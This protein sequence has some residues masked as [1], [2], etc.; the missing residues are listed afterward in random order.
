SPQTQT[1]RCA[2]EHQP[3]C[4]LYS[5][6][7]AALSVIGCHPR[8]ANRTSVEIWKQFSGHKALT[9]VQRQVDL[10]PRPAGSEAIEKTRQYI[11]NQLQACGWR[12]LRQQFVDNTPRGAIQFVNLIAHF[13][14]ATPSFL[15]C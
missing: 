9:H 14:S 6:L 7:V 15:L 13:G 11:D 10:G 8:S 2:C 5:A 1:M 3:R 4:V 12:M